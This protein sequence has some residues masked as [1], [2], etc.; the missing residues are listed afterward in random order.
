MS[1]QGG[2]SILVDNIVFVLC[3]LQRLSCA[4]S[5]AE[6]SNTSRSSTPPDTD[7]EI[8]QS[9]SAEFDSTAAAA[10]KHGIT[11]RNPA[12]SQCLSVLRSKIPIG[13]GSRDGEFSMADDILSEEYLHINHNSS[14]LEVWNSVS[15]WGDVS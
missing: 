5:S 9:N 7:S 14:S 3:A 2:H 12:F 13:V 11:A 10:G 8:T 15:C 1:C 4:D 6:L